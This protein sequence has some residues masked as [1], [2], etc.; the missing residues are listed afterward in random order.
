MKKLCQRKACKLDRQR[1][2]NAQNK[3]METEQKLADITRAF[4]NER[5]EREIIEAAMVPEVMAEGI[6]KWLAVS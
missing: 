6:E 3:L 5:N 2:Y 4:M 1:F